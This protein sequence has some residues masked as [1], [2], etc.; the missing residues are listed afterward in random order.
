M[1]VATG[2]RMTHSELQD[3]ILEKLGAPQFTVELT[4]GDL[5]T[6]IRDACRWFTAKRGVYKDFVFQVTPGVTEFDLPDDVDLIVDVIW[7]EASQG[8][9]QSYAAAMGSWATSDMPGLPAH[10]VP[11]PGGGLSAI[12]QVQQYAEMA[13]RITGAEP[14]FTQVRRGRARIQAPDSLSG[15]AV[16]RYKAASLDF[17]DLVARDLDLIYR[18]AL[19]VAKEKLARVRTR[20][21]SVPSSSGGTGQDGATLQ[22]EAQAEKEALEEEI[23]QSASPLCILIG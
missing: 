8:A 19:A 17:G 5:D 12:Y 22:G 3:W 21:D 1:S 23:H 20:F 15:K 2:F 11:L 10:A 13:Q 9:V 16:L 14:T 4:Q 18:Y 7:P 6:A